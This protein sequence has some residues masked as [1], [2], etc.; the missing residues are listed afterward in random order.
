M[1]VEPIRDMKKIE[2][3]KKILLADRTFGKRNH[4]LFVFGINSGLRISDIL[5]MTIADVA[6]AKG[7][8]RKQV[9][10]KEKKT[11]KNKTFVLNKNITA[12]LQEYLDEMPELVPNIPLFK[13]RKLD[14]TG[15]YK[16]LSRIQAWEILTKAAKMAG[17]ENMGTHTM[18]KT[19]GYHAYRA[20]YGIEKLQEVFNHSSPAITKRYIGITQDEINEIYISVNL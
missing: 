17:I 13:S 15:K 18:R 11:G 4:L 7:K 3:M 20:G 6:T 9:T 10:I 5:S 8:V 14:K 16:A 2:A 12:V 19:F 1:T